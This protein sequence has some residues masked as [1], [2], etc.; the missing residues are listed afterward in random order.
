MARHCSVQKKRGRFL[1]EVPVTQAAASDMSDND[2]H[3]GNKASFFDVMAVE[4]TGNAKTNAD[5]DALKSIMIKQMKSQVS[6]E[7]QEVLKELEKKHSGVTRGVATALGAGT[8]AATSLAAL[9][10]LGT[11]SGLSAAGVA[12]GLVAAGELLG[13]GMIIGLGVLA[14]PI[15]TL[16]GLGYSLARK[17]QKDGRA[18][19]IGIAG[20][21]ICEIRSQLMQY[22]EYF[23]EE[24][25]HIQTVL[26]RLSSLE[27]V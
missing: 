23:E 1:E 6:L 27:R 24:L 17:R 19:A 20:Q 12:T 26:E 9:S 5:P 16:G 2:R 18:A 14:A 3:L 10:S 4:K 15:A 21:K 13:G 11:V 25:A 7:L 22:K 8:G